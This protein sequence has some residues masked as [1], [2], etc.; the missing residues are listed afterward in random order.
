LVFVD[1]SGCDKR[2]GFRRT[3][4]SLGVTPVQISK[5]QRD[6]RYQILPAYAQDRM[7]LRRVFQ[8]S[9]DVDVFEDFVEQLLQHCNPW[10]EPKSVLVI[11]NASFHR[12]MKI[13][14]IYTD[15]VVK[16]IYLPPYSPDL[17][18]IEEFFPELKQFI[19]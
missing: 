19:N 3:G 17:N 1:K 11:D 10:P 16:L 8:G 12:T 5:F 4:W 14:Q 7:V 2:A 18:P 15:S 13:E 9:T 6:K